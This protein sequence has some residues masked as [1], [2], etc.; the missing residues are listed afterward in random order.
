MFIM[1]KFIGILNIIMLI[2]NIMIDKKVTN[3][4]DIFR[5]IYGITKVYTG[6]SIVPIIIVIVFVLKFKRCY[7]NIIPYR[8]DLFILMICIIAYIYYM[9]N[10]FIPSMY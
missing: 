5:T 4:N 3:R 10:Y 6:L 8:I 1:P 2:T 7:V 9:Y